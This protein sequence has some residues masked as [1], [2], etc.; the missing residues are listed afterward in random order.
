M[1][2]EVL[3]DASGVVVVVEKGGVDVVGNDDVLPFLGGEEGP[4]LAFTEMKCVQRG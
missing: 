3:G 2:R 4:W 1:P